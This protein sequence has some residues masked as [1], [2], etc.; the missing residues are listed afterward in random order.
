MSETLV[1]NVTPTMRTQDTPWESEVVSQATLGAG[2][3]HNVLLGLYENTFPEPQIEVE[4]HPRTATVQLLPLRTLQNG[5]YI[6]SYSL[7][8]LWN[9]SCKI[10]VRM[11][12]AA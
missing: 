1:Q 12:P 6:L 9:D 3:T 11:T 2:Q 4:V 7:K 5:D 8:N 10:V